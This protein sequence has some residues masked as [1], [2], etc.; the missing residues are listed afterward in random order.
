MKLVLLK[1]RKHMETYGNFLVTKVVNL[2]QNEAPKV[3]YP[4]QAQ[5]LSIQ[6]RLILFQVQL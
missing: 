6:N 2:E 4:E 3:I 5:N 1:H